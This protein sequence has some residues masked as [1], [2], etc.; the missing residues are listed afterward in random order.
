MKEKTILVRETSLKGIFKFSIN[1]LLSCKLTKTSTEK[2]SK[3]LSLKGMKMT[4][5]GIFTRMLVVGSNG[6]RQGAY[7]F[8]AP[9]EAEV[10]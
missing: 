1:K 2:M 6:T 7:C 8:L 9:K 4:M 10:P 5:F 3:K